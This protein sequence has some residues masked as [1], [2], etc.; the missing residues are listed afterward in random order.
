MH[1]RKVLMMGGGTLL[2][3][4]P[5]EWARKNGVVKGS[6]LAVDEYSGR[7]LIVRPIEDVAEKPREV[8]VDYP[9]EEI[10]HVLND[11]TGAYLL[12]Y[13]VIRIRGEKVV[14]R[15]DR[16]RIKSTIARLI[17]LEIMDEDSKQITI[18]FLLEPAGINP[19]RIV[20][21]MTSIIEGMIKD[22]TEG[23][24]KGDGRLLTLV[25]ERDDEIDRL[26]FL[27]VR[28]VRTATIRTELAES[29]ALT[30]VDVLDYRVLASFLE[31]VGDSIAE[32]SKNLQ[33]GSL[34]RAVA[35]EFAGCLSKLMRMEDLAIRSFLTRK[36]NRP[37]S[38]YLEVS[39]LSKEISEDL[40]GIANHGEAK[41]TATIETLGAIER[42]SRLFV[43][44]SDLALPTQSLA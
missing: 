24:L 21:R 42:V 2:V 22:T 29:Y 32:L 28:T 38:I 18:Q 41:Q 7:K 30:P 33:L 37:R 34:S 27:L 35:K 3:S 8:T 19:E 25:A 9:K 26:Y 36:T 43:D 6:T 20:N 5:K 15:E 13:N 10:T 39:Q 44:I 23:I 11:L 31:S 14:T 4:L 40:A 12:G 17:G 16:G 1:A